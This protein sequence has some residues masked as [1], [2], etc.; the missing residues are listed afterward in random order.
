M[1]DPQVEASIARLVPGWD[2]RQIETV[3]YLPGGYSNANYALT[4]QGKRYVLRLPGT[5][6]PFVD[7]KHEH[8]WYARM[9]RQIGVQPLMLDTTTGE[10]LTPWIDGEL[11]IDAWPRLDRANLVDYLRDLHRALPVDSRHYD[12]GELNAAYWQDQA[13]PYAATPYDQSRAITCHNDLNPWNVLITASGWITLDWEFVGRNDPVFD[14]VTLHQ[15][16]ELPADEL[17]ELAICYLGEEPS[18]L[19]SRLRGALHSFWLREL[20][21][22]HYQLNAGNHRDEILEQKNAAIRELNHLESS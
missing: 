22:A 4:Y 19:A 1:T 7:R 5:A 18:D 15:G 11:L 3:E 17:P 12:I 16:L 20:G 9:P 6:Q 10:M 8:A 21:W 14:L 13:P 2:V